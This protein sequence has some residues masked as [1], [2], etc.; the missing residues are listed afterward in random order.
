MTNRRGYGRLARRLKLETERIPA[1][2][3]MRIVASPHG[4][5]IHRPAQRLALNPPT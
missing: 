5:V 3:Q 1:T 2:D 4:P